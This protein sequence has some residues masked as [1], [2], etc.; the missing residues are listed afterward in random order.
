MCICNYIYNILKFIHYI[1]H[2]YIPYTVYQR[3]SKMF[4]E[5][6][7]T[8]DA[9]AYQHICHRISAHVIAWHAISSRHLSGDMTSYHIPESY[10]IKMHRARKHHLTLHQI[11]YVLHHSD[12]VSIYIILIH[13]ESSYKRNLIISRY[14]IFWYH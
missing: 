14:I 2:I 7:M 6:M 11:A 5:N 4:Y 8:I 10:H 1:Y 13:R 12:S 9:I 3:L